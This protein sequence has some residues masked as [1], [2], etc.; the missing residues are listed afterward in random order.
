MRA[1]AFRGSEKEAGSFQ[2]QRKR[3]KVRDAE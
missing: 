2:V 1:V 3:E